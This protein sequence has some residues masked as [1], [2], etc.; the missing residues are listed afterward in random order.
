[1]DSAVKGDTGAS[2]PLELPEF[3]RDAGAEDPVGAAE[4]MVALAA[5]SGPPVPSR[6][7]RERLLASVRELPMRYAP[8][9]QRVGALWDLPEE[10]VCKVLTLA[11]DAAAWQRTI[12]RGVRQIEVQ[13]GPRTANARVRLLKFAP[14]VRFPRHRHLGLEHVL[15]LEGSY[16]DSDGQVVGPGDL[17]VMEPGSEHGLRVHAGEPCTAALAQFGM[18]FTGPLLRWVTKLGG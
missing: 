7:S 4:L 10:R 12:L 8:F 9:F 1:M 15:V 6:S 5:L 11:K 3:V 16:T 17:Q 14:G 2:S 13:G 18:E